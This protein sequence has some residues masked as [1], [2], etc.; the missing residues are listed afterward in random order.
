MKAAALIDVAELNPPGPNGD[1][2]APDTRLDFVPM[3]AVGEDGGM[4]VD[5]QRPF[6][7]VTK[8][9]TAFRDSDVLVAKITP[10]FENNK[11]AL[12]TITTAYAYGSTEFHVIRCDQDQLDPRYLAYFLRQD[13]VRQAGERRMTGSAGQRR[14][15]K[16]FLE[17]LKVPL[18]PIRDQRRIA[19]ILDQTDSLRRLRQRAIDRLNSL[20]HAIFYEMFGDPVTNSLCW[21]TKKLGVIGTLARGISK[22]RPRNDPVLLGGKYPLIQTGD[23]SNADGYIRDFNATYSDIGLRQSRLWPKGTLC[24]TIAANIGKTAILDLDACFP[25]SVVGFCPDQD[26]TTEYV[27]Y[28]LSFIQ[29]KLE[30]D[31]PQSAQ[32]NINLAILSEL[33]IPLPPQDTQRSFSELV[34]EID[35]EKQKLKHH[36]N[37]LTA[38]FSSLQHRAFRGEL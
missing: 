30:K 5:E 8:G 18:P 23:V 1:T 16:K 4:H 11:I 28:W 2:F 6:R 14:V 31:A 19:A 32:K 13:W 24:I 25:D 15:P 34:L 27:Q 26:A 35:I 38:L 21:A 36:L 17:E 9:Y 12:A 7:E 3:A 33:E 20:G 37:S 29:E 22:H 10:C